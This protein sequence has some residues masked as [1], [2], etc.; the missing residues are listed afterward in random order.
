MLIIILFVKLDLQIKTQPGRAE[1]T[2][3]S[4]ARSAARGS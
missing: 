2:V 1:I 3:S 4:V